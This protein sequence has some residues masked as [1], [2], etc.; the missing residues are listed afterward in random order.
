MNLTFSLQDNHYVWWT[1]EEVSNWSMDAQKLA[2]YIGNSDVGC[3]NFR[4]PIDRM[5]FNKAI[6]A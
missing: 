4:Q 3:C 5:R 6:V 1:K 2:G